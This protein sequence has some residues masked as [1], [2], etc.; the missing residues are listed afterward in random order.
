[1]TG[2]RTRYSFDRRLGAWSNKPPPR[3]KFV[4]NNN[5]RTIL[6][7]SG[8]RLVVRKGTQKVAAQDLKSVLV[9]GIPEDVSML[10]VQRVLDQSLCGPGIPPVL[11]PVLGIE[12]GGAR[13]TGKYTKIVFASQDY[14]DKVFQRVKGAFATYDWKAT[15][16][17]P[18]IQR[19]LR[20]Q[21]RAAAVSSLK[22]QVGDSVASPD[23][24]SA[25]ADSPL[26]AN[27]KRRSRKGRP[28]SAILARS[29]NALRLGSININ[30]C[31][32]SKPVELRQRCLALRLDVVA[33]SETHLYG[34]YSFPRV[35]GYCWFGRNAAPPSGSSGHASGGVGFLV[36]N[37]LVM[38]VEIAKG[39]VKN[40]LWIKL[41]CHARETLFLGSVYLPTCAEK[42]EVRKEGFLALQRRMS[43]FASKGS[44]IVLGDFNA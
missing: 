2:D 15:K 12:R 23:S 35:P 41:K 40:Q 13:N 8:F 42:S 43:D 36:K 44:V 1:L 18:F 11:K 10:A 28:R 7:A 31:G 19:A 34:D 4:P 16:G 24:S 14:R 5:T 20:R 26:L 32:G 30:G 38:H 39:K 27:A 29:L 33:V 22:S 3:T 37:W 17:M 9:F 25:S 21:E 6:E